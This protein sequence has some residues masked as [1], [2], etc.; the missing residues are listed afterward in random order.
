MRSI[1]TQ[2]ESNGE[3]NLRVLIIIPTYNEQDNIERVVENLKTN[4]A[5][6]DYVVVND[7]SADR[8]AQLCRDRQYNLVSLPINLGLAGA[9]QAGM[10]YALQHGYDAALQLDADGQHRPEYI[11][12]MLDKLQEGFDIV[13]GSRFVTKKKPFTLRMMG[14]HLIAAAIWLTTGKFLKDPTSGMRIY[15]RRMIE[16]FAQQIN[17]EPEPDTIS[18]LLRR[19]AKVAEVQIEMDERV[20]GVSYFNF[21]TSMGYMLRMGI[22]ILLLQW[23]RGGSRFEEQRVEEGVS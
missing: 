15:D 16:Q 2:T 11:Q 5:Q 8:T 23:F 18:Y 3:H 4:Y 19:G 17:H 12:P 20:A 7:G 6:F 22:S 14:S 10:K 9:F 21:T 13:I 1:R